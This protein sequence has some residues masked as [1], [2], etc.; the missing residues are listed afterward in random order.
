MHF[1]LKDRGSYTVLRIEG[2][3]DANTAPDLRP[4]LDKLVLGG[5]RTVTVDLS[6]LRLI[7]SSGVGALVSLYKRMRARGGSVRVEG[8]CDQPL[9]IFRL[10]RLD[11][12]F[13][14]GLN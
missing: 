9:A 13:C 2:E 10:L 5:G 3:L 8:I 11:A 4:T 12:V 1:S 7:D 14:A 6:G